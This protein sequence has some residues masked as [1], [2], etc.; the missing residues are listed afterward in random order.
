MINVVR[1]GR[2][3]CQCGREIEIA[4]FSFSDQES[5][6]EYK[7]SLI[8]EKD[9]LDDSN[10]VGQKFIV[11][12]ASPF[13]VLNGYWIGYK[14]HFTPNGK[15]KEKSCEMGKMAPISPGTLRII[16]Q[17]IQNDKDHPEFVPKAEGDTARLKNKYDSS[18]R[19]KN[20]LRKK[21]A[22]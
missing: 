15:G 1:V 12:S 22:K 17:A 8:A 21:R 3:P 5:E 19:G 14:P 10:L 4:C 9:S 18:R 13:A 16:A 20:A 7:D 11:D 6:D 2:V